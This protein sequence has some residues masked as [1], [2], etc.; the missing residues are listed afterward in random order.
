M[1][2][3][4]RVLDDEL[5][6]LADL[7]AIVLQG[8]K[9]VGK[10]ETSLQRART[11]FRLD[12]PGQAEIAAADP[13]R[14]TA[15]KRPILIDE[16][17][18][19]EPAWDVVRAA[20]DADRTGG[21]FLLTG[22]ASSRNA[23][24]HSGATRMVPLRMRPMTLAER[25]VG[26]P[27]V[28]LRALL[29]GGDPPIAGRTEIA[30]ADYVTEIVAS[31]FPG[32]RGLRGRALRAALDGYLDLIAEREFPLLG[33]P[34]RDPARLMRWMA[35][36]AA[37]TATTATVETLRAAAAPD[38]GAAPARTTVVDYQRALEDLWV[39]EPLRAWMPS[40][41]DI[42]RITGPDT[43]HLVDPALAARLLNVDE[44]ALLAGT[45]VPP[46]LPRT[47]TLLGALFESLAALSVRVFA[48]AAEAR[49]H[50]FRTKAGE[51]EAD[52]IIETP[53]RRI[54]AVD[55]KL[56][57]V[58]GRSDTEHL[59]WLRAHLGDRF[60]GGVILSTGT[61]AYRDED[62]IAIIPLALLGP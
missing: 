12:Q 58:I 3:R 44:G 51:R 6:A 36:T 4:R 5:D 35:A 9:G 8:A 22:S 41:S 60:A 19:F 25:G 2:Y 7:P 38:G 42:R 62:G 55:A 27:T 53:A 1:T 48:Q 46:R 30:L 11:V 39:Y 26:V 28:S 59:R 31:G 52:F 45:D 21:Q 57:A 37:A 33:Q 50:H 56:A 23:R 34:V 47:G 61:E 10:T 24:L 40:G 17:Q 13:A 15:G 49:V 14:L 29:A 18:R 43:H 16:W 32:L 54:L 20:V